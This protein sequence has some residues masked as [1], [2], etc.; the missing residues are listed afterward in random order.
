MMN[1]S[2]RNYKQRKRPDG[3]LKITPTQKK[4]VELTKMVKPFNF[5]S[6]RKDGNDGNSTDNSQR[7]T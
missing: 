3:R 7:N 5:R 4:T 2:R 6:P 1:T